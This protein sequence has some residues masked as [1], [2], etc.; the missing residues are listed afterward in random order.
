MEAAERE[1]ESF[2]LRNL[3]RH[4]NSHLASDTVLSRTPSSTYGSLTPTRQEDHAY[5][6]S[7][8]AQSYTSEGTQDARAAMHQQLWG[9]LSQQS[10]IGGYTYSNDVY[11]STRFSTPDLRHYRASPQTCSVSRSSRVKIGQRKSTPFRPE[12][13]GLPSKFSV[14]DSDTNSYSSKDPVTGEK[15]LSYAYA[16]EGSSSL[17]H[18][19]PQRIPPLSSKPTDWVNGSTHPY[20]EVGIEKM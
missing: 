16:D 6:S 5:F 4:I 10:P 9:A 20:W 15:F 11:G 19:R 18:P 12:T 17:K 8:S 14:I 1:K 13:T 3:E 7:G 2:L